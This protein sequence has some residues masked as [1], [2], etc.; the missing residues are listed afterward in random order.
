MSATVNLALKQLQK[1]PV[2]SQSTGGVLRA[3][4]QYLNTIKS[5]KTKI[6]YLQEIIGTINNTIIPTAANK[7]ASF[8]MAAHSFSCRASK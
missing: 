8:S 4:N 3:V 7:A 1:H 5:L 6:E 2:A